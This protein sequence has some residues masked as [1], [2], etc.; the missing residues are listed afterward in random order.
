M[1]QITLTKE[2]VYGSILGFIVGDA[3]GVPVEF[4]ERAWLVN[5]PV[6]EMIGYGTYNLPPGSWSDDSS[7]TLCLMDSLINNYSNTVLAKRMIQWLKE[8]YWNPYGEAC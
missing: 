4:E 1:G 7:L 8:G 5:N 6:K 3:L 2:Q